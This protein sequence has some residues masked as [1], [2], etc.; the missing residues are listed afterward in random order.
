MKDKIVRFGVSLEKDLLDIFD[1]QIKKQGYPT[2][3]KAIADLMRKEIVH[4]KWRTGKQIAGAIVFI[5][6]HHKR[7]IVDRII[8]IQHDFSDLVVSTQHVHLS[9]DECLE[10][11]VVKGKP[12]NVENL[13][14]NIRSIKGVEHCTVAFTST[15]RE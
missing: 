3:S 6:N 2:R 10:I 7:N 5:Y 15:S 14:N 11:V 13:A 8:D 1:E 9:H 12:E 4:H